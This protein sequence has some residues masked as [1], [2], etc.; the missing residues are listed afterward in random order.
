MQFRL[1]FILLLYLL[2]NSCNEKSFTGKDGHH[3]D[4]SL[5]IDPVDPRLVDISM[6]EIDRW[7]ET[8][9]LMTDEIVRL[10]LS[11]D[12]FTIQR[13]T[14]V[15]ILDNEIL[16]LDSRGKQLHSLRFD[17]GINTPVA[18]AGRGPGELGEPIKLYRSENGFAIADRVNGIHYFNHNKELVST[19]QL[20]F[21]PDRICKLENYFIKTSYL[22]LDEGPDEHLI[23]EINS[24]NEIVNKYSQRYRHPDYALVFNLVDGPVLCLESQNLVINS[25]LYTLPVLEFYF[26]NDDREIIYHFEDLDPLVIEYENNSMQFSDVNLGTTYH[27]FSNV[28]VIQNR[29]TIVQ[30]REIDRPYDRDESYN[31]NILSYIIDLEEDMLFYTYSIPEIIAASE[32]KILYNKTDTPYTYVLAEFEISK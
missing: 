20:N 4:L 24:E 2:F 12:K 17:G 7:E 25:Y 5:L 32:E 29:F 28:T 18:V 16:V 27:Q 14:D 21:L 1:I 9:R 15:L 13:F 3:P 8:Y 23:F 22:V 30:Y 31:Y 19:K 11:S 6:K 26:I 10:D